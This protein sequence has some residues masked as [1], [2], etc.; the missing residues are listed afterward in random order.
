MIP[1]VMISHKSRALTLR[2]ESLAQ[3]AS[4]G[5]KPVV[6]ESTYDG[7]NPSAEV[8][9]LGY[10]AL[11]YGNDQ[12]LLFFEDDIIVNA[13]LLPWHIER[14]RRAKLLVAFC[15]VNKRHYKY[16]IMR[17]VELG[18]KLYPHFARIPRYDDDMGFHGSMAMFLPPRLVVY[19]L[20]RQTE[21][22]QP[23]GSCLE[24]PVI[25]PDYQRGKVTGFDFWI[26]YAAR[27][28]PLKDR[29]MFAAI[30]NSVD[31]VGRSDGRWR[32]PTFNAGHHE[33]G[34]L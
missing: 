4:V 9:R 16:S 3:L 8:R 1:A 22:Q 24:N 34:E 27:V 10:E 13:D 11:K 25:P 21:F 28:A 32:S 2:I 18:A 12:G 31:H 30:P 15:A 33:P 6:I 5:I 7:D 26:K 19:G 23:D 17:D 20:A 29:G 14:A